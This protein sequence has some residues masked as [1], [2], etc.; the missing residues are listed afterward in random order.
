MVRFCL[1]FSSVPEPITKL[2]L[3]ILDTYIVVFVSQFVVVVAVG[4][5]VTSTISIDKVDR[6][7]CVEE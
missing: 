2:L 4:G 5:G 1:K 6:T 7:G 3:I